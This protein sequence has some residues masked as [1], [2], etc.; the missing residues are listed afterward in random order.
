MSRKSTLALVVALA[1]V[2]FFFAFFVWP[3]MNGR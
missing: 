1:V 3:W 2:A